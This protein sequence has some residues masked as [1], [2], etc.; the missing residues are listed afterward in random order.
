MK[1]HIEN[2]ECHINWGGKKI[3]AYIS[4]PIEITDWEQSPDDW[5]YYIATDFDFRGEVIIL[6]DDENGIEEEIRL[7]EE[8]LEGSLAVSFLKE[9]VFDNVDWEKMSDFLTEKM[10]VY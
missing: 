6:Y 1:Y 7:N 8:T 5:S 2:L 3:T 9:I 10:E 4:V